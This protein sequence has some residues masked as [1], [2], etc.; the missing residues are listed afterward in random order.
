M[1]IYFIDSLT[2]WAVGSRNTILL[3][4]N[5]GSTTQ[6]IPK[7]I[8]S[9]LSGITWRDVFFIDDQVGWIVGNG[10]TVYRSDDGGESWIKEITGLF[11]NLNAIYMFKN[12]K[13]WIVGD[14]GVILT[15]TPQP[16]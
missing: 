14:N 5:D 6:W 9:E 10:G 3:F 13:G 1:A 4:R 7:T 2:G 12:Q 11:E 8:S 15:Y 16:D